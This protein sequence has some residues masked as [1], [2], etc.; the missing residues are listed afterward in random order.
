M[1]KILCQRKNISKVI[2]NKERMEQALVSK[3]IN[4]PLG[5]TREEKRQMILKYSE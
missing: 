2:I 1:K 4:V 5:L 3:M